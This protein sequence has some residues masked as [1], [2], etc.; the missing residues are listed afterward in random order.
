LHIET[1]P[2][3]IVDALLFYQTRIKSLIAYTILP[4]HIHLMVEVDEIRTLSSFLR[5]FKKYASRAIKERIRQSSLVEGIQRIGFNLSARVW[6][7][8]TMDHCI[9]SSWHST[10]FERHLSYLF[11]NSWK[12]LRIYPK[13]FPYHNFQAFV[14]TGD[15][16]RD[17]F[18]FDEKLLPSPELYE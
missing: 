17:F 8:G 6:Q 10:D 7:P 1:V 4:D 15:F 18:A 14:E 5:D 9:R 13:D 2:A 3:L 12:H 16:D 11:Y